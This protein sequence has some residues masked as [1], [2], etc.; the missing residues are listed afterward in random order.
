MDEL[1]SQKIPTV[2]QPNAASWLCSSFLCPRP[3]LKGGVVT[4]L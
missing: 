1:G 4:Y 3:V 2:A